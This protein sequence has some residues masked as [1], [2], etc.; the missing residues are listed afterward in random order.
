MADL[1]VRVRANISDVI[2]R[3]FEKVGIGRRFEAERRPESYIYIYYTICFIQLC[4]VELDQ[5]VDTLAE[6]EDLSLLWIVAEDEIRQMIDNPE[7]LADSHTDML[8]GG[9]YT[10][11]SNWGSR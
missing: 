4:I 6:N 5:A 3:R 1:L 11:Y 10:I 2:G 9:L 8:S 7:V